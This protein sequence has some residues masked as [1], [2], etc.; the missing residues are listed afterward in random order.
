MAHYCLCREDGKKV[1]SVLLGRCALHLEL[2]FLRRSGRRRERIEWIVGRRG[3][4]G[5]G[6]REEEGW[7]RHCLAFERGKVVSRFR[8]T[9]AP[10][11]STLYTLYTDTLL[12][13]DPVR[14]QAGEEFFFEWFYAIGKDS[15]GKISFEITFLNEIIRGN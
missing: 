5:E 8:E 6:E 1:S 14:F 9:V 12:F 2:G 11:K 10:S 7:N 4:I 13:T 15:P 3:V